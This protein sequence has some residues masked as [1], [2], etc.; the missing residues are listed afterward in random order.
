MTRHRRGALALAAATTLVAVGLAGPAESASAGH[1][2]GPYFDLATLPAPPSTGAE[3]FAGLEEFVRSYPWRTTG[4]PTEI[5]AGIALRD[6]MAG[7]GY[8]ATIEGV[9]ITPD[10][11]ASPEAGLKAVTATK[12]GTT[13]PDEWIT[14][15]GHYDTA[16]QTIYGA[17]DNGSG[18][19]LL[20]F[21][22]KDLAGVETNRSLVFVWY[23]GEEEGRLAS[24]RHARALREAG[25][26][27]T[28]VLGF[29][30]VGIAW[31]VAAPTAVNC[32]CLF[33]GPDDRAAFEPLLR[34]V[35]YDF[36]GFPDGNREVRYAGTNDRNSDEQSFAAQGYPTLRWAGM[37]RAADYPAYHLPDDT[38]EQII[39][40]SGGARYYEEGIAN[41]R[42]SAYYT[43]LALDNHLPE[44]S[45]TVDVTGL[46]TRDKIT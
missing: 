28:A 4:G 14:F 25:Q 35:N 5:Q 20:R 3:I 16:P 40:S 37:R 39:E 44:P 1:T 24:I 31:P 26:E 18:T 45:F 29:D 15:I 46:R 6:E 32:L 33:H 7:L 12:Q 43:A 38:I 17:Y 8:D 9:P 36:L 22:A 41:T 30:M 42:D 10:L 11:P 13:R 21:L 34:F 19:N 27:I 23:N 2:S